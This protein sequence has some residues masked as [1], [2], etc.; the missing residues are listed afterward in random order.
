MKEK[1]RCQIRL[2]P[3]VHE[4]LKSLAS[5]SDL[6]IN[7]LVE[8][9][10]AWSVC[11]AHSGIPSIREDPPLIDT[12]PATNVVWF[13]HDGA[14]RDSTGKIIDIHHEPGRVCFMLDFRATRATVN[15][16][17]VEDVS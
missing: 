12:H 7:Q 17:E 11:N 14:E 10:L 3:K 15:G 9:I 13:G 5:K 1:A 4:Q 6:S 16:W 8:G 2:D